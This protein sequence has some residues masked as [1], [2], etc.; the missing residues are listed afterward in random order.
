MK[1]DHSKT[2]EYSLKDLWN[3]LFLAFSFI[4]GFYLANTEMID[5]LIGQHV[6]PEHVAIATTF[7]A[8]FFKQLLKNNAPAGK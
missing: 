1:P 7:V 6:A 8:Y 2:G 3:M 5:Q 4:G